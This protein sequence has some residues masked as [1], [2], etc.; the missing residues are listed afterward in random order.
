ME[1]HQDTTRDMNLLA[2]L[3]GNPN[4]LTLAVDLDEVLGGFVEPLCEFH[5][6]EYGTS[7]SLDDFHSY[8]FHNVWGGSVEE[9]LEKVHR[10][11]ESNYFLN[12]QTISGAQ[13]GILQLSKYFRL[14]CV[15]SRQLIVEE[16]TRK[17]LTKFYPGLFSDVLFGNHWGVQGRKVSKS[18]L[19][20]IINA[21]ALIDDSLDY[22]RE[23]AANGIPV[24]LFDYKHQ[25]RWNKTEIPLHPLINRVSD[26]NEIVNT[27]INQYFP[28]NL[29]I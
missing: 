28:Q 17:W 14:V 16:E 7:L 22:A 21:V 29:Q 4:Q 24:L 11:F 5:N 12:M 27:C 25:Y 8:I 13:E 9:S 19:C 18:E 1:S 3:N 20:R 26:W 10:F 23:C 15:T 2:P 6:N